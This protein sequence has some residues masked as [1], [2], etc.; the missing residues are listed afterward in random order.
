MILCLT[1][2]MNIGNTQ[3]IIIYKYDKFQIFLFPENKTYYSTLH[4]LS[5]G[6][7]GHIFQTRICIRP[8]HKITHPWLLTANSLTGGKY[9]RYCSWR[10]G[11]F[12][13]SRY[14][15]YCLHNSTWWFHSDTLGITWYISRIGKHDNSVWLTASCWWS[16]NKKSRTGSRVGSLPRLKI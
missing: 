16:N 2:R 11:R 5:L 15:R 4:K 7:F 12:C 13:L 14:R 6:Y 3:V 8:F 9:R 1:C 10:V